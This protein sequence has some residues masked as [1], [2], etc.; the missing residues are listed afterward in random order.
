MCQEVLTRAMRRIN[1]YRGEASLFTWLCRFAR[2]ASAD[3]WSARGR[4]AA[5]LVNADD[6]AVIRGAL[7][8]LSGQVGDQPEAQCYVAELGRLVQMAL[9]H[10]PGNYGDV[11]EWKYLDELSIAEIAMRL[12]MSSIA[13]QSLVQRA[14]AAFRGAF[15]EL[16]THLRGGA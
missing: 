14:R 6:D 4:D 15:A 13:A 10:L 9:D 8:S 1:T 2:N 5:V 3:Y 12:Q 7:E 16:E 11:L